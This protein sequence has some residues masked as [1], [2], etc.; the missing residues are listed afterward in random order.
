MLL[1][2]KNYTDENRLQFVR[3]A[4]NYA[5][6]LA[7][8]GKDS[9]NDTLPA[10]V[11]GP[12]SKPAPRLNKAA[13]AAALLRFDL[14]F[15]MQGIRLRALA[16]DAAL[17]LDTG[18]FALRIRR[19][20]SGT[21]DMGD[22]VSWTCALD[23]LSFAATSTS[24]C[25][26]LKPVSVAEYSASGAPAQPLHTHRSV[27]SVSPAGA[28][29]RVWVLAHVHTNLSI[30]NGG[31]PDTT[32]GSGVEGLGENTDGDLGGCGAAA[33][34]AERWWRAGGGGTRLALTLRQT[35]ARAHPG[36]AACLASLVRHYSSAYRAYAQERRALG[37]DVDRLDKALS[38]VVE[39]G[40]SAAQGHIRRQAPEIIRDL[41]VGCPHANTQTYHA[42]GCNHNLSLRS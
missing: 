35:E 24:P 30:R 42:L 18:C 3:G 38:R 6:A 20:G 22:A 25:P 11:A 12:A 26:G 34:A 17:L 33:A 15:L 41:V 19:G 4:E 21:E 36:S 2:L 5:A 13:Q 10:D 14:R 29:N 39:T 28:D 23:G 37:L 9:A 1:L 32:G 31:G 16:P 8:G 40:R 27:S 7:D